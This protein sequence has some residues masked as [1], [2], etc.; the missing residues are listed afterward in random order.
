MDAPAKETN[1]EHPHDNPGARSA[2]IGDATRVT[3]TEEGRRG[4][5]KE[6][7]VCC[8]I[9]RDR[10]MWRRG[11]VVRGPCASRSPRQRPFLHVE[12]TASL[13]ALGNDFLSANDNARS[14]RHELEKLEKV[15]S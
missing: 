8:E 5:K 6:L 9:A 1:A 3:R 10:M 13:L 15:F 7:E 4:L 11:K 12:Q 2:I 14:A